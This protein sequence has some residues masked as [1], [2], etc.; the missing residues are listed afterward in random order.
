[1]VSIGGVDWNSFFFF[2]FIYKNVPASV[3]QLMVEELHME[4]HEYP[5][6][7]IQIDFQIIHACGLEDFVTQRS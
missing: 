3:K 7:L 2:L 1:M 6:M 5:Q 4:G